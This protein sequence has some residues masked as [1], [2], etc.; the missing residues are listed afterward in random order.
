MNK[1]SFKVSLG[2]I[3]SAICLFAMFLTGMMPLLVYT[4]PALAGAL[5]II[6]V[7]EISIKWAFV[8]YASV[9]LLSLFITPDKEAA[10]LFILLL[11]Y[12]PIIKSVIEKTKSRFL[13]WIIKLS[14]F[15]VA[16]ITAYQI[17]IRVVTSVDMIEEFGKYGKYGAFI[18]LGIGNIVFIIYDIALTRVISA[19]ISWFRPKILR[20]LK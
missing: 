15:N 6:M 14:I 19:Y 1:I 17:I 7:V 4:L 3:V 10:I 5:M 11:G 8:T 13:E 16:V 12:Y 20:K 2:G 18:L 9:G